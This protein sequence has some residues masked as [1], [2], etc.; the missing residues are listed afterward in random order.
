MM[1]KMIQ[2]IRNALRQASITTN[3]VV[4]IMDKNVFLDISINGTHADRIQFK[5]K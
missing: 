4:V 3:E 1:Q 2:S 5:V